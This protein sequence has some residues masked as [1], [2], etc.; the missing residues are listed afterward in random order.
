M[1]LIKCKDCQKEFSTDAKACPHC[2]AKL[3]LLHQK[4]GC[5]GFLLVMFI[6]ALLVG[7]FSDDP[8]APKEPSRLD[9]ILMSQVFVKQN[10]KAPSTAKFP[11]SGQFQAYDMVD[12]WEVSGY[13]DAQNGFGAQIRSHFKCKLKH[14]GG[15]RWQLIDLTFL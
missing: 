7:I 11:S 6:L 9:A 8:P 10:L 5:G 2:G 1:A 12:G 13:V 15:D 3:P 14:T 4:L